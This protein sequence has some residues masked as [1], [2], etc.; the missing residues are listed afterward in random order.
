[1]ADFVEKVWD[2]A[3]LNPVEAF[4]RHLCCALFG[5]AVPKS[6]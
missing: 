1:M 3:S 2:I 5:V 6:Q 4:F